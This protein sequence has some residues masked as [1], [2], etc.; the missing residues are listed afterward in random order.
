M[1]QRQP[2][3][4]IHHKVGRA[5]FILPQERGTNKEIHHGTLYYF[6][7]GGWAVQA[8]GL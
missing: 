8:G 6:H 2:K 5:L 3:T 7:P 4:P 1:S